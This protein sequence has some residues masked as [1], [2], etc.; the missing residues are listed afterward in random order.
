MMSRVKNAN[1][2][3]KFRV[4]SLHNMRWDFFIMFL[5]LY[6]IDFLLLYVF[7]LPITHM[8]GISVQ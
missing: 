1:V 8:T 7:D 3:V 2:S 6:V 5:L 4:T